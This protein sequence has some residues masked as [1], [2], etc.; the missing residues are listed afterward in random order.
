VESSHTAVE[1]SDPQAPPAIDEQLED[2]LI[3]KLRDVP[4]AEDREADTSEPDQ[5]SSVP[6][7]R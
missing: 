7:Q 5:P 1:R 6:N 4:L 3:D 2:V